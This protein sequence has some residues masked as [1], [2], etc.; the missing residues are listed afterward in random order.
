MVKRF[1]IFLTVVILIMSSLPLLGLDIGEAKNVSL[2]QGA[3]VYAQSSRILIEGA[4]AAWETNMQSSESLVSTAQGVPARILAEYADS[5]LTYDLRVADE[6]NQQAASVSPRILVEYADSILSIDLEPP[7]FISNEP[8]IVDAGADQTVSIGASAT[9]DGSASHDTDGSIVSYEWDFG[10]G[11]KS[12]GTMVTHTYSEIG[13]YTVILTVTDNRGIKTSDTLTVQVNRENHPPVITGLSAEQDQILPGATTTIFATVNDIDKDTLTYRW[14]VNGGSLTGTDTTVVWNAPEKPGTYIVSLE[15]DDGRGG[16]LGDSISIQVST[17][18]VVSPEKPQGPYVDLYGHVTDVTVGEEIIL[19]L[20]VVN[21]ITSPGK[22]SVQLTLRIPSGWSIT[23]SGFGHGAGGMRTNTYE[24]EQ[25]PS[26]KQ[27]EVHILANEAYEGEVIGYMDYYFEE[28][29][30]YHNEARLPVKARLVEVSTPPSITSPDGS[31]DKGISGTLIAVIVGILAATIGGVFARLIW[32]R[33][34]QPVTKRGGV[35]EDLPL[36]HADEHPEP[37]IEDKKHGPLDPDRVTEEKDLEIK[38]GQE[39]ISQDFNKLIAGH[40]GTKVYDKLP[41]DVLDPLVQAERNYQNKEQTRGAIT[42]FFDAMEVC[43]SEFYIAKVISKLEA[44]QSFLT[45]PDL[46]FKSLGVSQCGNIFTNIDNPNPEDQ[47]DYYLKI[48][49]TLIRDATL[50]M[51]PNLDKGRLKTLTNNLLEA[52]KIRNNAQH[53]GGE[54]IK[55]PQPWRK[56]RQNLERMRGIV[57]GS[58]Q[59]TSVIVEIIE[60]FG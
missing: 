8:P 38:G 3:P 24:I 25:G 29:T 43:L 13:T 33:V 10:D 48:R 22:L 19:Y 35:S 16:I 45:Q 47:R 40:L 4:D 6:L 46:R 34:H 1:V 39:G 21:P 17:E 50:L 52:Q 41:S 15:V 18:T 59:K 27:I 57:F 11:A 12:T 56:Q 49:W 60:I 26:P 5:I 31:E 55:G 51:Y 9:L 7:V 54:A 2:F 37:H 53:L 30:K 23:S 42:D 32:R 58:G 20:S 14:S 36:P 28:D 44:Q